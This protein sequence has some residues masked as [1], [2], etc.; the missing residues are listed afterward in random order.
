[1]SISDKTF[2]SLFESDEYSQLMAEVSAL[3]LKLRKDMEAQMEKALSGIPV[4]TR[5]ELDELYKTIYDLK[6]EV[7][8]LEP[9]AGN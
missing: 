7:R 4:A 8:Q 2:V 3:Q 1:M 5:T 6:K 9:H